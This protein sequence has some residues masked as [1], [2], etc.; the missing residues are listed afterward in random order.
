MPRPSA[1][2]TRFFLTTRAR[3]ESWPSPASSRRWIGPCL[4]DHRYLS[5][6]DVGAGRLF[7]TLLH[8]YQDT[9]F[10]DDIVPDMDDRIRAD[11]GRGQADPFRRP[12]R[13][14]DTR[15]KYPNRASDPRNLVW[16]AV[17]ECD[18]R[19][20]ETCAAGTCAPGYQLRCARVLFG[21]PYPS[22]AP[23]HLFG[24]WWDLESDPHRTVICPA[25]RFSRYR[26]ARLMHVGFRRSDNP[27][28]GWLLVDQA[29][30]A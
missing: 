17:Q 26:S 20:R 1:P 22:T 30:A 12:G 24:V 19:W 28:A 8:A 2:T 25:E 23:A 16:L 21:A 4:L 3:A 27:C 13:Y 6:I 7:D 10:F 14:P 5:A 18:L 29:Q 15:K 9:L 11:T